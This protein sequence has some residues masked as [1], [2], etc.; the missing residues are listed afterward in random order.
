MGILRCHVN[1]EKWDFMNSK[2][3]NTSHSYIELFTLITACY[4]TFYSIFL[5]LQFDLQSFLSQIVLQDNDTGMSSLK[6][7]S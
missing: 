1:G 6:K 7:P 5:Y 3:N 2:N 4:W